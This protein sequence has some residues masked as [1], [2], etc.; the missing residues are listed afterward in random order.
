LSPGAIAGISI[1]AVIGA[2]IIIIGGFLFWK[3]SRK[4]KEYSSSD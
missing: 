1:A 4:D 3:K 2:G